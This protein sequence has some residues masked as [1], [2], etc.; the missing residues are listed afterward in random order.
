MVRMIE[1][2]SSSVLSSYGYVLLF[3]GIGLES[4]IESY[5][6]SLISILSASQIHWRCSLLEK[7]TSLTQSITV[8]ALVP[9]FLNK[10]GATGQVIAA[11]ILN[12]RT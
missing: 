7:W 6:T 11:R 9:T 3:Q 8:L 4:K 10:D 2:G 12:R 5:L 1:N